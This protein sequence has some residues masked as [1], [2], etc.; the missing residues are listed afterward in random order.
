MIISHHHKFIF[1]H[2]PRT[3]GVSTQIAL[4][5]Y[6]DQHPLA[7]I[8][9]RYQGYHYHSTLTEYQSALKTY[10]KWTRVRNPWDRVVSIYN[11]RRNCDWFI[12][13]Q[14]ETH[15]EAKNNSFKTWLN[16]VIDTNDPVQLKW[17][18]NQRRFIKGENIDFIARFERINEDFSFFCKS[19][20]LP[21]IKLPHKNGY[22][23]KA[24]QDFYDNKLVKKLLDVE[25]FRQ[26]LDFLGYD[27]KP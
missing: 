17:I 4:K 22:E 23:R 10:F 7:H 6:Y 19:V 21:D 25:C 11:R 9:P 16:K 26:D 8:D 1:I 2:I 5:G 24:Y 18:F 14:Y 12:K 3:G 13:N 20:G 27:H 15:L